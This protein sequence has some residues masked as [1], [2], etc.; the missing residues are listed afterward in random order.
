MHK[1]CIVVLLA[2]AFASVT[3][4]RQQAAPS[5]SVPIVISPAE[6][7]TIERNARNMTPA[8]AAEAAIQA[9]SIGQDYAQS[10]RVY[11]N[12]ATALAA[13]AKNPKDI[14][15]IRTLDAYAGMEGDYGAELTW[16]KKG[17]S[18]KPGDPGLQFSMAN[19]LILRH[20][21]KEGIAMLRDLAAGSRSDMIKGA[22]QA[23]LGH[24]ASSER[25]RKWFGPHG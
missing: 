4:C 16:E 24:M 1:R 17:L 2:S 25:Y 14:V 11:N 9:R 6:R 21:E 23:R 13:I 20:R 19:T 15:A 5:S 12:K 22:A 3:A 8:Q 7:E 10:A 18:I